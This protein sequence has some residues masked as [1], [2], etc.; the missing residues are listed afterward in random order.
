M[1][2]LVSTGAQL[3]A[4]NS[5][6]RTPWLEPAW[7]ASLA[8]QPGF[9]VRH[10]STCSACSTAGAG[11]SAAEAPVAALTPLFSSSSFYLALQPQLLLPA[12]PQLLF[13]TS[14][15]THCRQG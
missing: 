5:A 15:C 1:Q 6:G 3:E 12:L 8:D 14:S 2:L 4:C 7:Q 11:M 9:S 13:P 10:S